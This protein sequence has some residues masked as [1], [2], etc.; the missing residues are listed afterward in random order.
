MPNL[1]GAA[2]LVVRD[3]RKQERPK[4]KDDIEERDLK[5]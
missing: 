2:F 5:R 4:A 3:V 1:P